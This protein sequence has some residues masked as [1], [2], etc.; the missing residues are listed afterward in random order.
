MVCPERVDVLSL[1]GGEVE[2]LGSLAA[3]QVCGEIVEAV[4]SRPHC[5]LQPAA[6]PNPVDQTRRVGLDLTE[7]FVLAQHPVE[8][9]DRV[10]AQACQQPRDP[11]LREI[12]PLVGFGIQR[13]LEVF[14]EQ[15]MPTDTP[16]LSRPPDRTSTVARSSANRSGFSRPSGITAVP[17]SIRLV[18]W[19]AAASRATGAEMPGCRCRWRTQTLS[20]PSA[21]ARSIILSVSSWPG[22]GLFWSNR[23]MVRKPILRKGI[24]CSGMTSRLLLWLQAD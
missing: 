8:V 10:A 4:G 19:L 15:G 22:L 6:V 12:L 3:N 11:R 14:V 13:G 20:K 16:G 17:N 24:P 18:R 2:R 9:T 1:D 23:P 21:S 7:K 5:G